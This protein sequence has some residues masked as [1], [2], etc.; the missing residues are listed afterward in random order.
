MARRK[1]GDINL[2]GTHLSPPL[3]IVKAF[4]RDFPASGAAAARI[5]Q[6]PEEG[7]ATIP[8][9]Q[10]KQAEHQPDARASQK[11]RQ[12]QRQE[13]AADKGKKRGR[14]SLFWLLL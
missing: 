11:R 4:A 9:P 1:F 14:G 12:S 5:G 7:A 6:M 13:A 3:G 2:A 8:F 10:R